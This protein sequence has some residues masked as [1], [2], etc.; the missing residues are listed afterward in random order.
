[1]PRRP[2][3][4]RVYV[5]L[6]LGDSLPSGPRMYMVNWRVSSSFQTSTSRHCMVFPLDIIEPR[7]VRILPAAS[8]APSDVIGVVRSEST[9]VEVYFLFEIGRASCRERV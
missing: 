2:Y 1:M 7:I 4:L 3:F 6:R 8:Y 5:M 9:Q